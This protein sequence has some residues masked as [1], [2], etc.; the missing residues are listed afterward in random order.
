MKFFLISSAVYAAEGDVHDRALVGHQGG[1]S[2]DLVLVDLRRVA[3]AT[4]DGQPVVAVLD[5][6][7]RDHLV[8]ALC[9][10]RELHG[11]DCVAGLDLIEEASWEVGEGRRPLEMDVDGFKECRRGLAGWH[12][13]RLLL[14]CPQRLAWDRMRGAREPST[15]TPGLHHLLWSRFSMASQQLYRGVGRRG[16]GQAEVPDQHP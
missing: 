11:I 8:P 5:T 13:S 4:F 14:R 16:A 6:P 15:R 9:P 7:P 1:E 2:L 12:A 10:D 3:D